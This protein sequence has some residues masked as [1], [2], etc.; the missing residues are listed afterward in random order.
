MSL[1]HQL[2]APGR[3]FYS[4]RV[5][6]CIGGMYW[7]VQYLMF[8]L[9]NRMCHTVCKSTAGC[10]LRCATSRSDFQSHVCTVPA[11]RVVLA[12]LAGKYGQEVGAVALTVCGK[13]PKALAAEVFVAADGFSM[14]GS[15]DEAGIDEVL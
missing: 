2:H 10:M 3:T 1:Q 14:Q 6:S 8:L 5:V 11:E 4:F 13:F 7:I 12:V 9:R 15:G